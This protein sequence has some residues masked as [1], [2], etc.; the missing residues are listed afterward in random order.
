[1]KL[2]E[3]I[4][5]RI[6]PEEEVTLAD[7]AVHDVPESLQDEASYVSYAFRAYVVYT[8]GKYKEAHA[9][10]LQLRSLLQQS[11]VETQKQYEEVVL[12][13][14][15][16]AFQQLTAHDIEVLF[17]EYRITEYLRYPEYFSLERSIR[18]RLAL[19]PFDTRDTWRKRIYDALHGNEV[20]ITQSFV[21]TTQNGTISAWIKQ[22]DQAVGLGLAETFKRVDFENKSSVSAHLVQEEK[23]ILKKLYDVYEF[24]KLTSESVVGFE[25]DMT[26]EN[27]SGLY[28]FTNGKEITIQENKSQSSSINTPRATTSQTVAL[29][30]MKTILEMRNTLLQQTKGDTT[31]LVQRVSQAIQ[32]QNVQEILGGLVLFAQ[33]H[34]L[35]ALMYDAFIQQMIQQQLQEQGKQD[36]L[37]GFK[38]QPAAPQYVA[39]ML[40]IVFESVLHI[41]QDDARIFGE[42]LQRILTV[43]APTYARLL[44]EKSGTKEWNI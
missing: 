13:L 12:L 8:Y 40:Y 30:A 32:K 5:Q 15:Y 11:S 7:N 28:L 25:E 33:L 29:P 20:I 14:W 43:T 18:E 36:M 9:L 16:S 34:T 39:R 42:K 1:M 22:Y 23:T 41:G 19:E 17:R 44:V 2:F 31:Q 27:S 6:T 10:A 26:L 35:D 38:A 21:N 3:D 4:Q 37:A 24:I